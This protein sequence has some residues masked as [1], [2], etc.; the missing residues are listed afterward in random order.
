[1]KSV[2]RLTCALAAT[3][4]FVLISVVITKAAPVVYTKPPET[5]RL[6]PGPNSAKAVGHCSLCHSAEYISTQPTLPRTAWK[7]IVV[8]MQK[9]HGAP[10][11]EADVEPIVEYLAKVYGAEKMEEPKAAR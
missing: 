7:A 2:S 10:I 8:K 3:A 11:P 6:K 4:L 5:A 1:M 9:V